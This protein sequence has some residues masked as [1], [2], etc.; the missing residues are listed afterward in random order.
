MYVVTICKTC[1]NFSASPTIQV[2]PVSA[3]FR[4]NDT[5]QMAMY[6]IATGIGPIYYYWAKYE[7]S[8]D[9]WVEPSHYA[10][11]TS[12]NLTFSII[13]AEDEGIYRCVTTNDD[14][15]VE[16]NNATLRVYGEFMYVC[17]HICIYYTLYAYI[18][19]L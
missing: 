9:T 13:T 12:P 8:S 2:H 18:Y 15:S 19:K 14:G 6:C 3:T 17:I 7:S 16:S 11:I 1:T 5:D 10:N 4:E